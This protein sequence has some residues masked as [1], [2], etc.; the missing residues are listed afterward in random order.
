MEPK[1]SV[2]VPIYNVE[3]YLKACVDS[4]RN[5]TMGEIEILLI[6]DGSCD[7]CSQLCDRFAGEDGRIQVFH[8][9]NAGVSAAR[10][11]GM[12]KASA[13]WL[14]FVD[15]DDW[16]EENAVEV[17]YRET[18]GGCNIICTPPYFNYPD[19]QKK[20][21][22]NEEEKGTHMVGQDIG[23]LLDRTMSWNDG[24]IRLRTAQGKLYRRDS[25]DS[26]CRFPV[27]MKCAED[28]IFNLHAALCAEKFCVLDTPVYHYRQRAGSATHTLHDDEREIHRRYNA[29]VYRFLEELQL[30]EQFRPYYYH[31]VIDGILSDIKLYGA[32]TR[33]W[34][35]LRAAALA[36]KQ[37]SQEP[38]CAQ[39]IKAA[40]LSV[41]QQRK[42]ELLL[43]MLKRHMYRTA[44]VISCLHQRWKDLF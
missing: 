36:L 34:K 23:F 42:K 28:V 19:R 5:Q 26:R 17:L 14:M 33:S 27:G 16:L 41:M 43:W 2:I 24:R 40:R 35:D 21:R 18:A 30:I 32:G 7:G 44:I 9:E 29:E 22:L 10:N 31:V 25:L 15:G 37:F 39:A 1:V 38:E 4:I 6:D 12:E 8:Q 13:E 20:Y 11:L 3:P